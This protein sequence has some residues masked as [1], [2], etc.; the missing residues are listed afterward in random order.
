[1]PP[2]PWTLISSEWACM[3]TNNCFAGNLYH[4]CRAVQGHTYRIINTV[5]HTAFAIEINY[6]CSEMDFI[7]VNVSL[8]RFVKAMHDFVS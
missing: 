4:E 1:M 3:Y 7:V 8:M 5:H 6:W 2:L